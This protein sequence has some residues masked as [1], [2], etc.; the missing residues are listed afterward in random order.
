MFV[1]SSI[2]DLTSFRDSGFWHS[3]R[4][5]FRCGTGLLSQ[6]IWNNLTAS[7]SFMFL[8]QIEDSSSGDD[9]TADGQCRDMWGNKFRSVGI[10]EAY[11]LNQIKHASGRPCWISLD[12]RCSNRGKVGKQTTSPSWRLLPFAHLCK[13]QVEDMIANLKLSDLINLYFVS[14]F[15]IKLPFIITLP[16][17]ARGNVVTCSVYFHWQA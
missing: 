6:T 7:M 15:G 11:K 16:C 9:S 4:C 8:V 3:Q 17:D 5:V 10:C 14:T 1:P 2:P 12:I 13:F